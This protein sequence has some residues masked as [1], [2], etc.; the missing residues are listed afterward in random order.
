M[1]P[2]SL[3]PSPDA[4]PVHWVWLQIPLTAT[5][6]LHFVAMNI[7]LGLACIGLCTVVKGDP[8]SGSLRDAIVQAIPFTMAFAINFGVAPLLFL[9][10]LY[11]QFFYTSSILMG[12]YWL[13]IVPL[14]IMSYGAAYL[15]YFNKGDFGRGPLFIGIAAL[16]LMAVAFFFSNNISLM[17]MPASWEGYFADR[18][19]WLLNTADPALIPRYLHFAASAVA[20]G[21]LA[22]A[23]YFEVRR[24]RGYPDTERWLRHGCQ[25]FSLATVVNFGIGVWFFGSLPFAAHDP[26]TVA[27]LLF[28]ALLIASVFATVKAL[29]HAQSFRV[30][31]CMAWALATILLMT[32]DRE[33]LRLA[34]LKPYFRLGELPVAAQYGPFLLFLLVFAGVAVVIRWL[35][36]TAWR[37]D[38]E[39]Q[40]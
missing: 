14:L 25:W 13:A 30:M 4:I 37:M 32:L 19:G 8:E 21:G 26:A 1:D 23:V 16:S 33:L 36:R 18:N 11:G 35:L 17:Q 15:A 5:T 20:M 7:V 2:A 39:V 31:P 6:F 38:K 29:I 34:S 22:I 3:I 24:R 28:L 12:S 9:Q 10:A 27:G 40:S